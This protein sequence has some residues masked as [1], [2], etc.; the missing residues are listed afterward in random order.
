MARQSQGNQIYPKACDRL[1]GELTSALKESSYGFRLY[2][3]DRDGEGFSALCLR[4][5]SRS[6]ALE[7]PPYPECWQQLDLRLLGQFILI[8]ILRIYTEM[9]IEISISELNYKG[10]ATARCSDHMLKLVRDSNLKM[11]VHLRHQYTI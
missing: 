5:E 3:E 9:M 8:Q 4:L 10:M 11:G 2:E 1:I 6:N 7:F